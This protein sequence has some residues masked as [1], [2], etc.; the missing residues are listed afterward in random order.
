LHR[1]KNT[2]LELIFKPVSTFIHDH[3]P[4]LPKFVVYG[5]STMCVFLFSGIIHEYIVYITFNKFSGDQI[6]FFLLQGLAVVIEHALKHQFK[7]LYIPKPI[8]FL[9]TFVFNG[10]TAGYFA[11]PWI[12]YFRRKNTFKY[13][14]IDFVI[15]NLFDKY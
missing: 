15:R 6:K 4:Y 2:W 13:S 9:L 1:F 12:S 10:I 7:Q 3:W 11:Q 14:F 8:G 5:I